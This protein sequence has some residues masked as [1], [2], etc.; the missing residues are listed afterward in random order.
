MSLD[1]GL[2]APV[3]ERFFT[4]NF[5]KSKDVALRVR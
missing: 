4:V 1:G 5:K 3:T 2:R